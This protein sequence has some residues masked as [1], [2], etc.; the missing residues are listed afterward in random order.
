MHA[1]VIVLVGLQ[2]S[3]KSFLTARLKEKL[4]ESSG[5]SQLRC[6]GI[7]Q[8]AVRRDFPWISSSKSKRVSGSREDCVKV[9]RNEFEQVEQDDL[10]MNLL[11]VIDRTNLTSE[12]RSTWIQEARYQREKGHGVTV[13]CVFL[14]LPVKLCSFRAAQRQDHEGQVQGQKAYPIVH[15]CNASLQR[16][17]AASEEFDKMFTICSDDQAAVF[18]DA[19][20][21]HVHDI[22]R[23]GCFQTDTLKRFNFSTEDSPPIPQKKTRTQ[24]PGTTNAFEVLMQAQQN[25]SKK[26]RSNRVFSSMGGNAWNGAL[27]WYAKTSFD[28]DSSL[29]EY[30]DDQCVIIRDKYPKAKIHFLCIARDLS[31]QEPLDITSRHKELLKHM[32]QASLDVLHRI[33]EREIHDHDV[34]MGFHAV[35]SMRQL[36]L[37]VISTDFDSPCLKT[38]KHWISFTNKDFF[39]EVDNFIDYPLQYEVED[40][41]KLLKSAPLMCPRCLKSDFESICLILEHYR[42]H[43]FPNSPKMP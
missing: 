28:K 23:S 39:L 1:L 12:Q 16:P 5:N 17:N 18:M 37:H 41:R 8:D 4:Q 43:C 19:F 30:S 9:F 22:V 38:R 36:H 6:I 31:L 25:L 14:D 11:V 34:R 10:G 40:K 13:F 29:V 3:G 15:R 21:S 42:K 27:A 2:G 35:P 20:L 26:R 7:N 24:G 32:K 33:F